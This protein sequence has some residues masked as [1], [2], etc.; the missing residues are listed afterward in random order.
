MQSTDTLT[1]EQRLQ[2]LEALE[3]IRQ[4]KHRYL[5][6]CDRKAVEDIRECFALGPIRIDYGELGVFHDRDS[7]IELYTRLACQPNVIDLHHGSNPEII[8]E[9]ATEARGRWAL[10]YFNLEAQSG[11]TRQLGGLYEDRYRLTEAGW[12]IVET[13]SHIHSVVEGRSLS[14]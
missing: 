1:I 9:S 10:Y 13:C 11:I 3:Q 8:L 5:N 12:R 7:F 6:A 14:G 2:Q 4:L